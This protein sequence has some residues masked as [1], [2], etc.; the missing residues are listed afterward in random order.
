M[1]ECLNDRQSSLCELHVGLIRVMVLRLV[2]LDCF[3]KRLART[4]FLGEVR[5]SGLSRF[6]G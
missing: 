3:A 1:V 2:V 4:G 6:C 5:C